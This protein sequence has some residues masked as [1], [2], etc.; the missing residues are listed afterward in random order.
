[1]PRLILMP[2]GLAGARSVLGAVARR[3]RESKARGLTPIRIG[4]GLHAGKAVIAQFGSAGRQEY[5]AVG[6]TANIASEVE[7]LC[8]PVGCAIVCKQE[9]LEAAAGEGANSLR[10]NP[11]KAHTPIKVHG[12]R[13]LAGRLA[14][15]PRDRPWSLYC[16]PSGGSPFSGPPGMRTDLSS[17]FELETTASER[18]PSALLEYLGVGDRAHP[19]RIRGAILLY[20]PVSGER[21]EPPVAVALPP[22]PRC[23]W[24]METDGNAPLATSPGTRFATPPAAHQQSPTGLHGDP[25]VPLQSG[26]SQ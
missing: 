5:P 3:N 14:P 24:Q 23:R 16:C 10:G 15:G 18:R 26:I 9:V 1:M 6:D 19:E 7:V 22:N 21:L 8:K 20:P 25:A 4:I 12:W 2:A 11:I 13:Q 17:R